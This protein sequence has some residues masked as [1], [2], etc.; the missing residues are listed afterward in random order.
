MKVNEIFRSIDGEVNTTG[1]QGAWT[2]FLRLQGCNLKCAWCDTKYAQDPNRGNEMSLEEV[3]KKIFT[4]A[5]DFK[6]RRITIT[7]GEPLLQMEE[8]FELTKRL[9]MFKISIETNG[10]IR[11]SD[12]L[13][14]EVDC[15]VVDYKLPSSGMMEHM[16]KDWS[17][18]DPWMDPEQD[19]IKFVVDDTRDI[20]EAKRIAKEFQEAK[21]TPNFAISPTDR[22]GLKERLVRIMEEEKMFEFVYNLQIHKYL[23]VK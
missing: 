11:P 12:V 4:L 14:S 7:G 13:I 10:S 23:G 15:F 1:G 20:L 3:E 18:M 5:N 19:I 21:I 6:I 9:G 22:L 17:W 8:V 16:M 2:I